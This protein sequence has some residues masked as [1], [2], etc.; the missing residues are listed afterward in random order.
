MLSNFSC[1]RYRRKQKG[2]YCQLGVT[3][4]DSEKPPLSKG[5]EEAADYCGRNKLQLS[6]GCHDHAHHIIWGSMDMNPQNA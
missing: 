6:V 2:T 3:P 5:L 4:N 1:K